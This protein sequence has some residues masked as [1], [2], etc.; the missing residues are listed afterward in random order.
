MLC[1]S[2][3]LRRFYGYRCV[4]LTSFLLKTA[5]GHK[6]RLPLGAYAVALLSLEV[7]VLLLNH[8]ENGL[9]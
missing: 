6:L 9:P 8:W 3:D 5:R 4:V 7:K 1:A 2:I